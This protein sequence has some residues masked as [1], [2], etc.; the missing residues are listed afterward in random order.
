MFAVVRVEE[1]GVPEIAIS[2]D[3]DVFNSVLIVV[4]K[5]V[6]FFHRR[7]LIVHPGCNFCYD[8]FDDQYQPKF[9]PF[10]SRIRFNQD[11]IKI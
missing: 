2:D 1:L 4:D 5:I 9:F 11:S 6:D 8:H 10:I 3:V 7:V